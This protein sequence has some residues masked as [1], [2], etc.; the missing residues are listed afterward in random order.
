MFL[1]RNYQPEMMDD[2]SI[3]DDRIDRALEELKLVN[4]FLGGIS[5]TGSAINKLVKANH[6][7]NELKIL[8]VGS[9][10]SDILVALKRKFK[11][12]EITSIDINKRASRYLKNDS[13]INYI[14]CGDVKAIPFKDSK[15]DLI[16]ASLF[17]HHFKEEEIKNILINLFPLC[18]HAIIVNDL[19]RSIF[20]LIG[21]K[22]LTGLFSRSDMVKNDA[23]LSVKR[24]FTRA[25]LKNIMDELKYNYIIK[26]KW[27]FRWC[28][29]IY[30]TQK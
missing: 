25:E 12:L 9:G 6:P 28:L 13:A 29:I 19:R 3:E 17:F 8:D 20:A 10:A 26:R 1:S 15:F 23:P 4:R 22:L 21:I 30:I 18:K 16:H 5:T 7:M 14:V 2:F 24:G 27:A 11:D